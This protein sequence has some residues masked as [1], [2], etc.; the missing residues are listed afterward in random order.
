MKIFI[1]GGAGFI[2]SHIADRLIEDG[3]EVMIF[4]NFSS[5][6]RS[7]VRDNRIVTVEGDIRDRSE[8]K[9]VMQGF[10]PDILIHCAYEPIKHPVI[11]YNDVMTSVAGTVNLIDSAKEVNVKRI[12]YFQ[13][14]LIYGP[15]KD[16]KMITV[17]AKTDPRASYAISKLCAEHYIRNSGI[18]FISFRLAN[19]YGPR[20]LT[21][22]FPVFFKK[23]MAGETCTIM[24][25]RRSFVYISDLVNL[26]E[27]AIDTKYPSGI[28]HVSS[29]ND[30]SILEIFKWVY[31]LTTS[32]I[33]DYTKH[34]HTIREPDPGS[35]EV[36]LLD[37]SKTKEVFD[38]EP[39]VT[40]QEGIGKTIAWYKE[41]GV[42]KTFTHCKNA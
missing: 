35:M 14:V 22:A 2:G 17:D 39:V 19:H 42:E 32:Y 23:I 8:V 5:G 15:A 28:Y 37:W 1:A 10:R 31:F 20:N 40:M 24:N 36:M 30:Y 13:T 21:G 33:F 34:N 27:K 4:D 18:D 16:E 25:E 26:V 11:E 9:Y 29:L 41:N 6:S 7:T 12:I 3:H 38:W